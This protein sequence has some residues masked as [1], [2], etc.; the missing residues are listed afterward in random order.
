MKRADC[1]YSQFKAPQ[2]RM[3]P[4]SATDAASN[5]RVATIRAASSLDL[6]NITLEWWQ[7]RRRHKMRRGVMEMVAHFGR[8]D[9]I[10]ML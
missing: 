1:D 3:V 9:Q 7:T 10:V 2:A 8:A 4:A 6:H 5:P